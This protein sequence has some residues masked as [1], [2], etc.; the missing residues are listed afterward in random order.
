MSDFMKASVAKQIAE[1]QK[2]NV[3]NGKYDKL[4]RSAVCNAISCAVSNGCNSISVD[5]ESFSVVN[6]GG[7]GVNGGVCGVNDIIINESKPCVC[8][9]NNYMHL[10]DALNELSDEEKAKNN[11][12]DKKINKLK[13][14][15]QE[16]YNSHLNDEDKIWVD[17]MCYLKEM[18]YKVS[19]LVGN[20]SVIIGW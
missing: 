10:I 6:D 2:L 15:I 12:N 11:K 8:R 19:V 3:V 14:T 1:T 20:G 16:E 18:K 5:V 13:E 17:F 4:I 9:M 7:N